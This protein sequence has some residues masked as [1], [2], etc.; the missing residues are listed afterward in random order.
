MKV[1]IDKESLILQQHSKKNKSVEFSQLLDPLGTAC[2]SPGVRVPSDEKLSPIWTIPLK[3]VEPNV[4]R[5]SNIELHPSFKGL[6]QAV[7]YANR[8]LIALPFNRVALLATRT[9]GCLCT[10][11]SSAHHYNTKSQHGEP[12]FTTAAWS[13]YVRRTWQQ[14][15]WLEQEASVLWRLSKNKS[16]SLLR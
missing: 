16:G 13:V 5:I 14:F 12:R 10:R 7:L 8:P 4:V 3:F 2:R 1:K 15:P 11:T 9:E 6:S